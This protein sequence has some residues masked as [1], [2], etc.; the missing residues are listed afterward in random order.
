MLA[1]IGDRDRG[2]RRVL[3]ALMHRSAARRTAR[4]PSLAEWLPSRPRARCCGPR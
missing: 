3:A 1:V 4:C 2:Q